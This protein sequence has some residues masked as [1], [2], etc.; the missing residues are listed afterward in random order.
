MVVA[1]GS[2]QP[3]FT[4]PPLDTI[5][6]GSDDKPQPGR[7]LEV[8]GPLKVSSL[9]FGAAAWSHFYNNDAYLASDVPLRTIRLALRYGIRTFDTSPYYGASEIVLGTALKALELEFPRSSYQLMTKCGRYGSSDF[10]YSPSTIR[11]S[12]ERSLSRLHTTY[13]DTVYLHDVEFVA[14][15]VMPRKEGNHIGALSDESE[16]Y[17]LKEGQEGTICGEGDQKILDGIAELRKMKEEGLIKNIGITGFPLPALL[18]LA[19]LVANTAPYRP[20]DVILSYC[21]LTL[22]NSTLLA[23]LPSFLQRARVSQVL[24]ASPLSMGLLTPTIPAWHPAPPKVKEAA[25][26]VVSKCQELVDSGKGGLPNVAIGWAVE[27]AEEEKIATVVG[28]SNLREVHQ[29]VGAW[30]EVKEGGKQYERF[31]AQAIQAFE[32]AG[33]KDWS[34]S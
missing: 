12:V 32:E 28:L 4:V 18:R 21:H 19:I 17:G 30:R 8:V 24:T 20:L 5:P 15:S 23:F 25:I 31:A 9:V 29:A 16:V 14:T 27:K 1:L 11:K 3:V 10:D 34:W 2:P 26:V 7:N 33:V 13:L 6:D 22:Q